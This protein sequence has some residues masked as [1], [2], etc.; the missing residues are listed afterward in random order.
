M[1]RLSHAAA[2][3]P[4]AQQPQRGGTQLTG[5]NP[6]YAV[7]ETKDGKYVTV[8]A[9]EGH[10]WRNLCEQLGVAGV[11]SPISSPKA[12]GARRCSA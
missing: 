12:N 11:H 2:T 4:S 6:C 9:L 8:G 10:F 1:E 3:S 7:Y 5:H